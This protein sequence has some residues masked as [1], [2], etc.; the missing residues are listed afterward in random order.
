M[1]KLLIGALLMSLLMTGCAKNEE[2]P[3]DAGQLCL[4]K[5]ETDGIGLV[6][7]AKEGETLAF[8]ESLTSSSAYMNVPE[9]TV[10]TIG[11]R[12]SVDEYKFVKWTKNGEEFSTDYEVTVTIDGPTDFIAVFGLSNGWDGPTA[13]TIEEVKTIGDVLALPYFG[14][15]YSEKT[16]VYAFELD[17]VVYRVEAELPAET[18]KALFDLEF[19]DPQYEQ[20]F[21]EL[22]APLEVTKIDNVTEAIPTQ[23]ELDKYVGLTCGD[24]ID[25]GWQNNFYNTEEMEF[26]FTY[27]WSSYIVKLDGKIEYKDDTDIEEAIRD[28]KVLSVKYEGLGNVADIEFEQN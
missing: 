5:V 19:E 9:G 16:F 18:S 20:K 2:I 26:G 1:K 27:G 25:Q 7:A 8:D 21:N 13:S 22:V 17:N 10:L 12:D 14:W 23:E 6:A 28:L 15:A 24:L 11:A 4:V 3:G